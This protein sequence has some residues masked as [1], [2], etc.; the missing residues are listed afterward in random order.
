MAEELKI[1]EQPNMVM[2]AL[3]HPITAG[4]GEKSLGS[5]F[6]KAVKT[7]T[8]KNSYEK[9]NA[10]NDF[11]TLAKANL[12]S[13]EAMQSIP[14]GAVQ[15]KVAGDHVLHVNGKRT[16]LINGDELLD[17]TGTQTHRI[18]QLA[19]LMY[20]DTRKVI[21]VDNDTL[22]VHGQQQVFIVGESGHQFIGKH[23][24]TAPE[25]YEWK[26]FERGFSAYKLDTCVLDFDVH[27][28]SIDTHV[29]DVELAGFKGRGGALEEV[30]KGQKGEAEAIQLEISIEVDIKGRGD[31]L[32]DIGIGTPFR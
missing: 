27:G 32:V 23:E 14:P 1:P 5:V 22:T 21:I 24:V 16:M 12:A 7:V 30:L 31:V 8:G 19:T 25:E 18:G 10:E 6:S 29:I 9:E 11:K 4:L 20:N 26:T 13:A 28:T 3:E 17:I 15:Q 2:N